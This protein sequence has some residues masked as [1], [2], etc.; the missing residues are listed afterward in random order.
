MASNLNEFNLLLRTCGS[1]ISKHDG[2]P[3]ILPYICEFRSKMQIQSST[4]RPKEY[5]IMNEEL[6]Y[7]IITGKTKIFGYRI[8]M[9]NSENSSIFD[10]G[11]IK[12]KPIDKKRTYYAIL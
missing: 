4:L 9:K 10:T 11:P 5:Q 3:V 8:L 6:K 7:F 1:S 12:T 2:N